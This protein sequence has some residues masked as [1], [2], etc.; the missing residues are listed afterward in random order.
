MISNETLQKN[1]QEAIKWEPLLHAAEIGVIVKEGVVTLTG[2]VDSYLKK[3]EVE[4]AA[5]SVKGVDAVIENIAVSIPNPSYKADVLIVSE[6]LS[7][8]RLNNEL[9]E[10][11]IKIEVEKGWVTLDGTLN[12]NYQK[13]SAKRVVDRI[14]GVRGVTNNILVKTETRDLV[15]RRDIEAAFARNWALDINNIEVSVIN[16]TVTLVGKVNSWY[17][18][19]NAEQLAWKA[20][21]VCAVNNRLL[22]ETPVTHSL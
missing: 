3:L 17:A 9:P 4:K 19:E 21:G 6:V 1:V 5:K 2:T 10:N 16:N 15:E 13:D 14:T 7:A 12:W 20:N 22:V 11:Q 18:R 8:L